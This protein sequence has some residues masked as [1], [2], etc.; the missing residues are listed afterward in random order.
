MNKILVLGASSNPTRYSYKAVKLLI[1]LNYCV[2]AIGFRTGFIDNCPIQVGQP[3]IYD[4]HTILL[5]LGNERQKAYYQ[6]IL[7]LNP[8]RIIF[9]PGT[10]NSELAELAKEK[11]IQVIFDCFFVMTDDGR[12]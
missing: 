1:G 3:V 8:K 5:Y 10:E 12:F 7:S 9:N 11:G 4:V 2:T 6:Y